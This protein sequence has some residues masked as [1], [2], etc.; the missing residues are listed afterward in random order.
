MKRADIFLRK[1]KIFAIG[2]KGTGGVFLQDSIP[3][4]A[5][6]DDTAAVIGA[7]GAALAASVIPSPLPPD[8]SKCRSV[9]P[10]AAGVKTDGAFNRNAT[11]CG[12]RQYDDRFD[13]APGEAYGSGWH[14]QVA[15]TLP[16]TT[17]IEDLT[18]AVLR[19]LRE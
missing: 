1:G 3:H 10:A 16:L 7:I 5:D 6:E 2:L 12:I 17:S 19:L 4:I 13:L 15:E 14:S 8:V 18:A 9:L 11:M